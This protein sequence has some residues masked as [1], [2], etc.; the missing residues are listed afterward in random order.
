MIM[1]FQ[2][3]FL[4]RDDGIFQIHFPSGQ[5]FLA[6]IPRDFAKRTTRLRKRGI[7]YRVV[8]Y[9]ILENFFKIGY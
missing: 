8:S 2:G 3:A 9:R 5:S 1:P 6:G 4:A 7:V